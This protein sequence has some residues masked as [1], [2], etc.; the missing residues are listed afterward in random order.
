MPGT[1]GGKGGREAERQCQKEFTSAT[2]SHKKGGRRMA[3]LSQIAYLRYISNKL[4][5]DSF[6]EDCEAFINTNLNQTQL[7]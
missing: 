5:I 1:R 4:P 7:F 2:P 6:L 3:A